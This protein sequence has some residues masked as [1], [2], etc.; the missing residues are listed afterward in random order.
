M[1]AFVSVSK[2]FDI[3]EPLVREYLQPMGPRIGTARDQARG[4]AQHQGKREGLA[5]GIAYV[6]T[7][8]RA[9]RYEYLKMVKEILHWDVQMRLDEFVPEWVGADKEKTKRL[10]EEAV[11]KLYEMAYD[12]EHEETNTDV[13]R[14]GILE[15]RIDPSFATEEDMAFFRAEQTKQLEA[16]ER[17]GMLVGKDKVNR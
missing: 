4:E 15:G 5:R 8:R 10:L 1:S 14:K 12:S 16:A 6:L 17:L 2:P 9:T 7:E 13:R 11:Q 3:L